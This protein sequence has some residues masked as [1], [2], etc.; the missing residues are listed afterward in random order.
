MPNKI[1][2]YLFSLIVAIIAGYI[3]YLSLTYVDEYE[4]TSNAY[5]FEIGSTKKQTI[6]DIKKLSKEYPNLAVHIIYGT[7]AGDMKTLKL[8]DDIYSELATNDDWWVLLN[9]NSEF[10]FHNII[11]LTFENQHLTVIHRK[12]QNFELP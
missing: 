11:R 5:G 3:G 6:E 10:K 8:T 4:V 2:L 9:N 7:R 12:R 1:A